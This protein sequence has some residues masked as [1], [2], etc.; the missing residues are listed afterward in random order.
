[1]GAHQAARPLHPVEVSEL[2]REA[3]LEGLLQRDHA[4]E[5]RVAS[6]KLE[7]DQLRACLWHL[8]SQSSPEPLRVPERAL[9]AQANDF[10]HRFRLITQHDLATRTLMISAERD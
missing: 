4:S 8:A 9:Q 5:R 2:V 7:V 10:S 1:M 3:R 6:L